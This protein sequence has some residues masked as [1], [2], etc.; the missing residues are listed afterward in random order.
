MR[1][2]PGE[3][4]RISGGGRC[5]FTNIHATPEELPLAAIRISA[6][7]RC[8]ATRRTTSSPWSSATASPTTRRRWASCSATA[9]RT[10]IIDML[11]GRNERRP[12]SSCGCRP[13]SSAI[14]QDGRRLR[15]DAVDGARRTARRWSSRRG[16]KSIPKMGATGF[17]YDLAA[18]FGLRVVET[19]PALVPLTF[20]PNML[21]RL[22]PLAGVAVDA[23]VGLRQDAVSRRPCCSPIA[24]SAARRSCRSRPTGARATRSR[25]AMLP[26][27]DVFEALRRPRA[28]QRPAGGA[29]GAGDAPAEAAG[30]D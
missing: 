20:E 24:A 30:A 4:I 10:Q 15:A 18:Q 29:D 23:V 2:A 16:G 25:I 26:G 11:A 8:A 28:R 12:A 19:R 21:E 22:A 7:R 5:N 3:K 27:V 1:A 9:R 17:G 6:S 13:A 14:E